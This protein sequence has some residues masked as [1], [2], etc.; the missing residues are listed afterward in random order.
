MQRTDYRIQA[1]REHRAILATIEAGNL[2]V[3]SLLLQQHIEDAADALD[4]FL[5]DHRPDG[6]AETTDDGA[7]ETA[8]PVPVASTTNAEE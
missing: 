8:L 7:V 5:A 1:E 6:D 3:A 2:P 4:R